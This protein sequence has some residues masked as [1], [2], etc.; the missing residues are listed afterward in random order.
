MNKISPTLNCKNI[1]KNREENSLPVYNMGL[2][3]NSLEQPKILIDNVVKYS[4]KK[5]YTSATGIDSLNKVIKKNYSNK[6]YVV[7]QVLFGNGLKELLYIVQSTFKG[8]IIH[9]TPSWVS[10]K[11]QIVILNKEANLIE[12]HTDFESGYKINLKTLESEL[13]KIENEK[14]IILFNNPNNPTSLVYNKEEIE[15]LAFVLKKYNCI[16][17][18]DEIYHNLVY[19]KD[20]YSISNILPDLTIRGSSVSKDLAC[21]GYRL[22][23]ITFPKKLDWFFYECWASASSI[24]SCPCTAI[25][26]ACAETFNNMEKLNSYFEKSIK[27]YKSISEDIKNILSKS[28]IRYY[29]PESSWYIFAN[30]DNYKN[31]LLKLNIKNSFELSNYLINEMGIITVAGEA[32]NCKG[33]NLRFSLVDIEYEDNEIYINNMKKGF[34]ILVIFFINLV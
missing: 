28:E 34:E 16:V 14:K 17:F 26:Y 4:S 29:N 2:G 6:N 24:Y 19:K 10:Y 23:W 7:D 12:I 18:A 22:G 8:K 15:S 32:F 3:A 21:G 9:I 1:I 30:F 27:I 11:E 5:E 13:K 20:F 31:S 25:Q 33:Y